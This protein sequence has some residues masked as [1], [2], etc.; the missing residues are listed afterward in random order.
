MWSPQ[1]LPH[2][3]AKT[4]RDH[5]EL[6]TRWRTDPGFIA[7]T[8]NPEHSAQVIERA[9][10]P[11]ENAPLTWLDDGVCEML[12]D[13]YRDVPAFSPSA[14][15]PGDSGTIA[16]ESPFFKVAFTSHM[17]DQ[18]VLADC[19][20]LHWRRI[21]D[22]VRVSALSRF[23]GKRHHLSPFRRAC[24]LHEA[25]AVVIDFDVVRETDAEVEYRI[26]GDVKSVDRAQAS[27]NAIVS[28]MASVWL[29]LS[30]PR[31]MQEDSPVVASVRR[32]KATT[33][34]AKK[35][36]V[37]VSVRTLEVSPRSGAR[38]GGRKAT[39]R[40][41]VRGHWRQ[42]AWGKNRALRKPVFIAPHTAGSSD[43]DIDD[44]P[45]VQVWRDNRKEEK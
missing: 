25:L 44:R 41:W 21:G 43:G 29:L 45:Q 24:P 9:I 30:Q 14:C 32:R 8:E 1:D 4:V 11:L 23:E 16:L 19:D 12:A 33:G 2:L 3:V 18:T 28:A 13:T 34:V 17:H 40:W 5:A 22:Q 15:M 31:V 10:M 20:A 36:P 6:A 35:R 39:S 27:G 37:R 42:Q 26:N 7:A 38:G